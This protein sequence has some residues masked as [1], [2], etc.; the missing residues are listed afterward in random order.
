MIVST[1]QPSVYCLMHP[2][3]DL[4]HDAIT[5]SR[6]IDLVL[7]H[8]IEDDEADTVELPAESP[9]EEQPLG[10]DD[11]FRPSDED[12][13]WLAS[14]DLE[15]AARYAAWVDH[16]EGLARVTDRDIVAAGQAVG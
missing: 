10:P 8:P 3:P 6:S 7:G 1:R 13:H 14:L 2:L 16:L 4:G 15:G 12:A 11:E 9:G 5:A